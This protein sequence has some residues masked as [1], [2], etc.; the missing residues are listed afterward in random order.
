MRGKGGGGKNGLKKPR[1]TPAYAGKSRFLVKIAGYF[2]DHPRVCGEKQRCF[3][4]FISKPGSPP[5]MRGKAGQ[6][7]HRKLLDRI[8][9]AYAGKS[10]LVTPHVPVRKDHPRVCGEKSLSLP[11]SVL[12]RGS[13]PRMRGKAQ[14]RASTTRSSR[15]HPR[16]CGE[17]TKKIP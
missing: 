5:R 1:I 11:C 13:P 4:V 8:T 14:S 3:E 7:R 15:D 10:G 2:G 16:V 12:S 6:I 9:P 17:K